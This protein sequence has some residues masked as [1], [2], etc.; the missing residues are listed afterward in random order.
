MLIACTT[1]STTL[2][3]FYIKL[4]LI[5]FKLSVHSL[6][7]E[8]DG[9]ALKRCPSNQFPELASSASN[10]PLLPKPDDVDVQNGIT[11]FPLKSFALTNV[12]TGHAAIP[13]HIGYPINTVS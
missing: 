2:H 6:I 11:V 9:L 3:I 8:S 4:T 5:Y 13:H 12:S 1:I 7:S 10:S